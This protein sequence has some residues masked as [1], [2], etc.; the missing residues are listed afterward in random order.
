MAGG[1]RVRLSPPFSHSRFAY[2]TYSVWRST[3]APAGTGLPTRR[4][5]TPTGTRSLWVELDDDAP[6][7]LVVGPDP[8]GNLLE[9]V[10]L[11]GGEV[12]LVIHAMPLRH[13]TQRE[14]FGDEP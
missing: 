3:Q 5:G 7:Y 13:S 6:R 11:V 2:Y 4:S 9:L 14:V 8:A 12:E 10:V 1:E